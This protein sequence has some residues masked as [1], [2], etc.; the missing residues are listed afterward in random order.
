MAIKLYSGKNSDIKV[1]A[2]DWKVIVRELNKLDPEH[3]KRLKK[4]FKEIGGKAR[5][6]VV[7]ELKGLGTRGPMKGMRHGGRTGWGTNYGSTGGPVPNAKRVPYN[8]VFVK[9]YNKNKK[10]ATGI[11]QLVVRSG[12]TV[13]TDL[14]VKPSG[15]TITRPYWKRDRFGN[16][17]GTTHRITSSGVNAMIDGLGPISK[18]SKRGK[19]R[20]VYPGF[21]KSYP[22]VKPEAEVAIRE[23]IQLIEKNLD[24][25]GR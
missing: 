3:I 6:G 16:L 12:A 10:G 20:N 11:A 24:R 17:Y 4:R 9:A 1:Y 18:P 22:Q 8:S 25:T 14:A 21:D 13:I 23:A 5:T 2:S 19:S 15:N 7:N